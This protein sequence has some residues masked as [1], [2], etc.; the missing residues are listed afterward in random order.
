M[1]C[2]PKID[3]EA[4]YQDACAREDRYREIENIARKDIWCEISDE[5]EAE[6]FIENWLPD[7]NEL[8]R[9]IVAKI[10]DTKIKIEAIRVR[11]NRSIGDCHREH[12]SLKIGCYEHVLWKLE[13]YI[14]RVAEI[15]AQ[16]I[17]NRE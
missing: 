1:N 2:S 17:Y 9:D 7:P 15:K 10:A 14:D 11:A 4:P 6:K 12:H 8:L 13:D 5:L 3:L 16:R